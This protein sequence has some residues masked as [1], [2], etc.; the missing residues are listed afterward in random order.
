MVRIGRWRFTSEIPLW[1]RSSDPKIPDPGELQQQI[2]SAEAC[3]FAKLALT[4]SLAGQLV[5]PG[6]LVPELQ[7]IVSSVKLLIGKF[8]NESE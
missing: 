5:L 1:G 2:A 6:R 7:E 4:R 8:A 3:I